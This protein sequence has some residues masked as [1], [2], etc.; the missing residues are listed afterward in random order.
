[1]ASSL[2]PAVLVGSTEASTASATTLALGSSVALCLAIA[3]GLGFAGVVGISI[4]VGIACIPV[5][6]IVVLVTVVCIS[7]GGRAGVG[8]GRV[9]TTGTLLDDDA[10]AKATEGCEGGKALIA[11]STASALRAGGERGSDLLGTNTAGGL[12][13]SC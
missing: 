1:M 4:S 2:S 9:A 8:I 11:G 3:C 12:F 6:G 7:V 10:V 13:F 5:V